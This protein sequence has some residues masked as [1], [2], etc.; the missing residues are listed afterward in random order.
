M[1]ASREAR[2]LLATLAPLADPAR[3]EAE[4][5]YL[6]SSLRFL[7][8]SLP[9]LRRTTRAW[10]RANPGLVREDLVRL[11]IDLW[12]RPVHEARALAVLLLEARETILAPA[13]LD[14]LEDLLRR[15]GTWAYVDAVAVHVAGPLVERHPRL[16]P[17]LDRWASDEDFW[18]R[19]SAM[20]ALL[21][22]LRRGDGDWK[23]FVRYAD[24]MLDEREF[25]IRKAIGWVLR[26]HGKIRPDRVAAFLEPR[27]A[28]VSG[29][30]LR[31]AVKYLPGGRVGKTALRSSVPIRSNRDLSRRPKR[32]PR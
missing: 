19:R 20:L 24:S 21:L 32:G 28:R 25:F 2:A 1:N 30:T 27:L 29:V 13:D 16:A 18:L 26:E 17:L 23:R 15:S 8:V 4:K 9:D 12:R 10:L 3:A 5:R 6:K 14:L 7:G 11:V 22:P 31:E